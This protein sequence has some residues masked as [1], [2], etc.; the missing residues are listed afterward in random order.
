M[1][2]NSLFLYEMQITCVKF[3]EL[4]DNIIDKYL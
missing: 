1:Y 2:H 4:G 3:Q